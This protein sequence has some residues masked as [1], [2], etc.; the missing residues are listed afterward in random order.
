MRNRM[1]CEEIGRI[2]VTSAHFSCPLTHNRKTV[3]ILNNAMW[4]VSQKDKQ[5][6]CGI[7]TTFRTLIF[8]FFSLF[9]NFSSDATEGERKKQNTHIILKWNIQMVFGHKQEIH[10]RKNISLSE[11]T[12]RMHIIRIFYICVQSRSRL[13]VVVCAYFFYSSLAFVNQMHYT[14]NASVCIERI[15]GA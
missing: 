15:L 9:S 10:A 5:I 3:C 8:V 1:E 12:L 11:Q 2:A 13:F 4:R 14:I 6:S 7:K